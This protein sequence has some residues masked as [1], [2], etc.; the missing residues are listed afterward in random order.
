MEGGPAKNIHTEEGEN[1]VTVLVGTG[2]YESSSVWGR[3]GHGILGVCGHVCVERAM[4][5]R[6]MLRKRACLQQA[7]CVAADGTSL[8][9]KQP[10]T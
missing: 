9:L 7:G 2:W 4:H 6:S 1:S 10:V 3:T 8:M 5:A